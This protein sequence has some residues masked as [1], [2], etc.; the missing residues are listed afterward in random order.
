MI[1]R[2]T[3]FFEPTTVVVFR[4][5][6]ATCMQP[7]RAATAC[8]PV[9]VFVET[10][11]FVV[12]AADAA[13]AVGTARD[14][15]LSAAVI[16]LRISSLLLRCSQGESF[17]VDLSSRDAC[18]TNAS[19][20]RVGHRRRPAD[21]DVALGEVGDELA[22]VT[23]REE[24]LSAQPGVVAAHVVRGMAECVELAAEDEILLGER[25]VED[26][27]VV[28]ARMLGERAHRRDPDPAGD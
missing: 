1:L 23:R 18:G 22:Q 27:D 17:E 16:A 10:I 12:V 21:V 19:D 20:G 28:G 8:V 26:D 15:A 6:S 3:V 25:P 4:T 13:A 11:T 24:L 14:A 5:T 7:P 2:L 9:T